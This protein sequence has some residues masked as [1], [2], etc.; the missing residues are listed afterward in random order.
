M[1]TS[2]CLVLPGTGIIVTAC[3]IAFN[4]TANADR[5]CG[6]I[7]KTSQVTVPV[8][9]TSCTRYGLL[10][11]GI[12]PCSSCL[13]CS[14]SSDA[15]VPMQYWKIWKPPHPCLRV[16]DCQPP[17]AFMA[18][19]SDEDLPEERCACVGSCDAESSKHPFVSSVPVQGGM[20]ARRMRSGTMHSHLFGQPES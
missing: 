14:G 5:S 17:A 18:R 10:D 3:Q 9:K 15:L 7:W 6:G 20:R 12:P 16:E 4:D 13:H 19:S 2:P 1:D 8:M 11:R